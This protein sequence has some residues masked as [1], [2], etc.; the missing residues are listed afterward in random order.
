[1]YS[2]SCWC[3]DV[4][5]T[6]VGDSWDELSGPPED[7]GD[8]YNCEDLHDVCKLI[9]RISLWDYQKHTLW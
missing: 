4:M 8:D 1:M 7:E 9:R 5:L 2:L 6:R 3:I